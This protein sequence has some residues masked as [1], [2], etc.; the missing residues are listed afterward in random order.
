MEFDIS[1]ITLMRG[2]FLTSSLGSVTVGDSSVFER[3]LLG[4]HSVTL[5]LHPLL[6]CVYIS[7]SCIYTPP[8]ELGYWHKFGGRTHLFTLR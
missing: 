2:V 1:F 6:Y 5:C 8:P 3:V 4:L 7:F